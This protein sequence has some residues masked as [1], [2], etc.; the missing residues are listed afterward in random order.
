MD[1]SSTCITFEGCANPISFCI[2]WN[3]GHTWSGGYYSLDS[4]DAS[5]PNYKPITCA[6][7]RPLVGDIAY[8]MNNNKQTVWQ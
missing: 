3:G 1:D 2:A 6:I 8:S 4:C 5:D 7:Y